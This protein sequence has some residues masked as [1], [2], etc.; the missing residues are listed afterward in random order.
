MKN[1]LPLA[2]VS[3]AALS[4][5]A[6]VFAQ[7]AEQKATLEQARKL[8]LDEKYV[9]AMNLLVTIYDPFE[10][11]VEYQ[12]LLGFNF[13]YLARTEDRG[14]SLNEIHLARAVDAAQ[15]S[16]ALKAGQIAILN[17]LGKCF[18][19][20][21][22]FAEAEKE[23]RVASALEPT[24]GSLHANI[25]RACLEQKKWPEAET[26]LVEAVKRESR[27]ATYQFNLGLVRF[28]QKKWVEAQAALAVAVTLEPGN[29]NA[30]NFLGLSLF[31][32]EKWSAAEPEFRKALALDGTVNS[33]PLNVGAALLKQGKKADALPFVQEARRLGLKEHWSITELGLANAP[34][35]TVALVA[36]VEAPQD[37]GSLETQARAARDA[38]NY[39]AAET[40]YTK[41]IAK[42]PSNPDFFADRG[43][44]REELKKHREAYSDAVRAETLYRLQNGTPLQLALVLTN[45][46]AAAL[47]LGEPY[48]ALAEAFAAT[49]TDP[50]FAPGWLVRADAY[51]ALGDYSLATG[52][53]K[54]AKELGSTFSRNYTQ[55]EA[56]RNAVGKPPKDSVSSEKIVQ[57]SDES[58]KMLNEK[59]Y[60]E[61]EKLCTR[62]IELAPLVGS[63]WS[64]R[65]AAL[66]FL[67][68]PA[69]AV[70]DY[71]TA[72][73]DAHAEPSTKVNLGRLYVRRATAYNTIGDT[74][75]AIDD[76]KMALKVDPNYAPAKT[77]LETLQKPAPKTER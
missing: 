27:N 11:N 53:L 63:F 13:Y 20:Q 25:G 64:L 15:S 1:R 59:R 43:F 52:N 23:F 67:A 12:N 69:L 30:H 65:G 48:R 6:P 34:L 66:N 75:A 31:R 37:A 21:G 19:E 72:I 35:P 17:L 68:K 36:P 56:A 32:Q 77:L 22:K 5:A 3:L 2:F 10:K 62:V 61:A 14:G 4:V 42:S 38:K 40:L 70:Q 55:E 8:H 44:V 71:A 58:V 24:N 29:A 50:T 51:Y 46:A 39:E 9:E 45:R 54:K 18:F 74:D 76:C 33:Y 49:D 57:D 41:L 26:A 47:Q 73:S 7:T 28:E 60:V 16:L